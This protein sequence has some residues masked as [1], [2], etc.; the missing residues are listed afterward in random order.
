MI[1][2]A[3]PPRWLSLVALVLLSAVTLAGCEL[4]AASEREQ[5]ANVQTILAGTPSVTATPT[6][7]LTPTLTPTASPTVGP[8]A[9]PTL[10]PLPTATPLP[11]TPTPNPALG[12]FS[13][14]DQQAGAPM[15]R[16]AASVGAVETTGF[17]AFEQISIAFELAQSN[18]PFGASGS[19]LSVNDLTL[20]GD[21]DPTSPFVLRIDLPGWLHD[22]RFATAISNTLE[23][24]GTRTIIS[25]AWDAPANATS[26]ASLLLGLNE[27]L[28]YRLTIERNPT[29]LVVAV[30]RQSTVVSSS[31]TLFS[32]A[33]GG[34]P[35]LAAPLFFLLDGDVW[36]HDPGGTPVNLS[37]SPETETQLAVSPTGER[38]AFCRTVAG[39]DPAE[40]DL[41]VPGT[42][43]VMNADGSSAR[44]LPQAGLSC[45]DP[46]FS[47]D[48]EQIAFAVDETGAVPTQR[49]IFTV[50]ARGGTPTRLISGND[51]WSR[52]APQ[53]LANDALIFPATAQDGRSTLFLRLASGEVRD[54]G[55]NLAL[56]P[57]GA[58][59]YTAFVAPLVSPDGTR[60]AVAAQ[61]SDDPGRDLLLISADGALIEVL[62]GLRD[63]PVVPTPTRTPEPTVTA[64]PEPTATVDPEATP[65]ADTAETPTATPDADD[66]AT[67]TP[68]STALPAEP[69]IDFTAP[70]LREGP[71][72]TRALGW[73]EAGELIYLSA[74]C[75]SEV[76][77]DY[78]VYRWDGGSQPTLLATGQR[79]GEIGSAVGV[80]EGIVYVGGTAQPG[81]HGMGALN[82]RTPASIWLWDL[83]TGARNALV[84][85]ERG[86]SALQR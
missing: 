22:E 66:E 37:D 4:T 44:S 13:F 59:R 6:A 61:R 60:I 27:P 38:I 71:F 17:P 79:L 31:D 54:I 50:P 30:A 15:G 36:R 39:L 45:A 19:C 65:T 69:E 42:L 11:P 23:L 82:L 76:L 85:T 48:G 34:N 70:V 56:A 83:T 25:A 62:G 67:P 74:L 46:A 86:I 51:E 12:N 73:T 20:Q 68:T 81:T 77:L 57:N 3:T 33:G 10:T 14:C 29:R 1:V 49:T 43:W 28:P 64:T 9:T 21:A 32:P 8:T 58:L 84:T 52:F 63:I 16:F 78:Q 72:M 80:G 53:W 55:A 2:N 24:S 41:A 7:T 47:R 75:A 35:E 40:R 5:V 26:G 18:A